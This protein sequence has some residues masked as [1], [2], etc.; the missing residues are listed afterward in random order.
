MSE[1][2]AQCTSCNKPVTYTDEVIMDQVRAGL[3][4]L[5]IQKYVL[6]HPEAKTF[7]L[8]KLLSF[9]EG[10]ESVVSANHCLLC[11]ALH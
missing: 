8:E 4:D 7:N 5:E 1:Y 2:S 10:K 11:M 9:I 6:S 3:A